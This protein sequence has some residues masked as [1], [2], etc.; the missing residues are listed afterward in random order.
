MEKYCNS[1]LL[2]LAV[3]TILTVVMAIVCARSCHKDND[4][5]YGFFAIITGLV[6]LFLCSVT[7]YVSRQI[8]SEYGKEYT[9]VVDVYVG[10]GGPQRKTF[11]SINKSISINYQ[12]RGYPTEIRT[13]GDVLYRTM[14]NV[15]V[16]SYTY[17]PTKQE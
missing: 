12:G 16:V 13:R 2:T 7:I 5:I 10:Q 3:L 1:S 8:A 6:S 11:K 9:M 4:E 17:K 14:G 15:E